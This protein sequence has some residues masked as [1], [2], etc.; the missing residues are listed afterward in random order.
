MPK[1]HSLTSNPFQEN[2][3]VLEGLGKSCFIIDPGCLEHHEEK[4]LVNLIENNGLTPIAVVNTHF[5]LDHVFGINYCKKKWDIPLFGHE[6]A[7][8]TLS[9]NEQA[10]KMYGFQGFTPVQSPDRLLA[11]G[12]QL[13]LD[14]EFLDIVHVPGHCKEHIAIID[15][16]ENWVNAGDVLFNGSIGRT[17]LPG[18]DM[19]TLENSIREELYT[20]PDHYVVYC[21][22]GPATTIGA[23]KY[24]NPFVRAD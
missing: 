6:L 8:F 9:F 13:D 12:D 11:H 15:R 18:G 21:G 22:H 14:G 7:S 4:E 2:T 17:D 3:Y 24:S 5:H 16:T 23:E 1:V 10:A 19:A 20:L